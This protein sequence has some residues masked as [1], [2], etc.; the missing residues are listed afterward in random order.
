MN[1]KRLLILVIIFVLLNAILFFFVNNKSSTK[2]TYNAPLQIQT[3]QNSIALP[4]DPKHK[5]ISSI[6]FSYNF[7][8]KVTNI[9]PVG[10]NTAITLDISDRDIPQFLATKDTKV[11]EVKSGTQTP[12]TIDVVKI[13][14]LAT[15]GMVY[16]LNKRSWGLK[17]IFLVSAPSPTPVPSK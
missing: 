9:T 15:M 17:A 16:D 12:S 6:F 8:G 4:I 13:G 11:F 10:E 3:L 5:G 14:S 7:T 1:S 2:T